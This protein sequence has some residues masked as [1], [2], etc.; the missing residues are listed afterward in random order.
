V[1]Y[2]SWSAP[3]RELLLVGALVLQT[4]DLAELRRQV[5]ASLD[6]P[7]E[8]PLR[9]AR[10]RELSR[11]HERLIVLPAWGCG[12]APSPG[13]LEGFATFG[14]LAAE[15][16]MA[17]NSYYAA[18]YTEAQTTTHCRDMPT[19]IMDGDNLDSKAAYVVD[20][21][22]V[23]AWGLGG[24]ASH[25]CEVTDGFNL[26]THEPAGQGPGPAWSARI[27]DSVTRYAIGQTLDFRSSG[28]AGPFLWLGWSEPEPWGTWSA[29]REA[30]VLLRPDLV[31]PSALNVVATL[32]AFVSGRHPR[33]SV[34]VIAGNR[35][36][37]RW[38]FDSG[39]P[40][41]RRAL[42]PAA[43]VASS[44]V[45]HLRFVIS[46][47]ASPASL[48]MSEDNRLLGIGMESLRIVRAD[49]G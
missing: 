10:W 27:S 14:M 4:A 23:I 21:K 44:P 7:V 5:R 33:L 3:W 12:S 6:Q 39:Q 45:L 15:Q 25:R 34:S 24:M 41:E 1:T 2:R 38:G 18:R 16:R 32:R 9:A 19:K 46:K 20:D 47:P 28:N 29:W 26:C 48:G 40:S 36:V 30:G 31:E 49:D 11:D 42:I 35:E 37:G 43:V 13:G 8:S 22:F 17:T